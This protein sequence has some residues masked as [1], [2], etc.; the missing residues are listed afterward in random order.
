LAKS[1]QPQKRY[2]QSLIRRERNFGYRSRLR[3]FLKRARLA[4]TGNAA[5]K[6]ELVAQA[7][8][9]LDRMASRGVIHKNNASR[10]KSRLVQ[11]LHGDLKLTVS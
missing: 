3:T 1:K 7:C 8:R 2:R 4:I 11:A 10:H 9:E 5:D 6:E